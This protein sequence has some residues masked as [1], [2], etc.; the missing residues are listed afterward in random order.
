MTSVTEFIQ[1]GHLITHQK[2]HDGVKEFRCDQCKKAF[3]L[4]DTLIRHQKIHTA[5]REFMG[6]G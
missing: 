4:N 3:T 6:T 5:V 2:I 1:M